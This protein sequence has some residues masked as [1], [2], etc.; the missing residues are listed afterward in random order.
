MI[1]NL[2]TLKSR[3]EELSQ[4]FAKKALK[5]EHGMRMFPLNPNFSEDSMENNRYTRLCDSFYAKG[6]R[7]RS[8][9]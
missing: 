2:D 5:T 7:H 9:Q 3:H 6:P 4:Q 8:L 1:L